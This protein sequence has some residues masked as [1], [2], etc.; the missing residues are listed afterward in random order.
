MAKVASVHVDV[1]AKIV[2][3]LTE[4]EAAALDGMF[5]YNVEAFLKVFY[6]RMGRAYVQP[7]EAGVRSLHQTIRG[8]VSGPLAE[9]KKARAAVHQALRPS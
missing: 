1:K 8:V 4:D 5:G 9:I 7:H 2:L 6:E 3:E